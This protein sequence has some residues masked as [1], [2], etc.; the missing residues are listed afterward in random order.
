MPTMLSRL[1]SQSARRTV[2][3]YGRLQPRFATTIS[4]AEGP[5]TSKEGTVLQKGA[6]RDPELYVRRQKSAHRGDYR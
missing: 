2:G 4:S 5:D 3:G 6:K 1:A